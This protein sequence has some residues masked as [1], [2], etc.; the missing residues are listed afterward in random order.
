MNYQI[1]FPLLDK[2]GSPFIIGSFS[3]LLYLERKRP[4]RP[5][6]KNY[7]K[8]FITNSLVAFPTFLGLRLILIP[9]K[10]Q[11]AE[12]ALI[13]NIGLLNLIKLPLILKSILAFLLLDYTLY[14]WHVVTHKLPLLWRFHNIHHTD[15]DLTASTAF[16]FHFLEIILSA[17][18]RS[19]GVILIGASPALVLIY[20]IIFQISV[21]FHHSNWKL[22]LAF[23]KKLQYFIVTPRMHGIHHST[24][25]EETDSN[26]SNVFTIWDRIHKTLKLHIPQTA[27]TI[28]VPA[29]QSKNQKF[30][31]SKL[32]VLPF[33]KQ[34]EYWKSPRDG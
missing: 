32:L 18:F 4:L 20:E 24:V 27:I 26:Y 30:S 29:F 14:L 17:V 16:R 23:E 8:R 3:I 5:F 19:A 6:R 34:P 31:F 25:H 10:V 2:F 22:P 12:W 1:Y 7:F 13:N 28:G 11:A 21:A 33:K 15:W 9:L